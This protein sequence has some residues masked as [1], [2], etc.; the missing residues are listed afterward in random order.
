M[1][2]L[3][4]TSTKGPTVK[5]RKN[6]HTSTNAWEENRQSKGWCWLWHIAMPPTVVP[7]RGQRTS[8]WASVTH[9]LCQSSSSA[10]ACNVWHMAQPPTGLLSPGPADDRRGLRWRHWPQMHGFWRLLYCPLGERGTRHELNV[11][12]ERVWRLL[13]LDELNVSN[14]KNIP[15]VTQ[16]GS[17]W[18]CWR[19]NQTCSWTRE[20]MSA[21]SLCVAAG[22][23]VPD[24]ATLCMWWVWSIDFG[25]LWSKTLRGGLSLSKLPPLT[26]RRKTRGE[27]WETE[28]ITGSDTHPPHRQ[29]TRQV[30]ESSRTSDR[31]ETG[32]FGRNRWEISNI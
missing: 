13:V 22:A 7:V 17:V 15:D 9:A 20:P 16:E 28:A 32:M 23:S 27:E 25:G 19:M 4:S 5:Q 12:S 29:Y 8:N 11:S 10:L 2:P 14:F 31:Q 21:A 24:S 3:S 26:V 18:M 1:S 30:R 6:S